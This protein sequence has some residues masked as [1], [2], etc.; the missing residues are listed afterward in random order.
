MVHHTRLLQVKRAIP[1]L[2]RCH[3]HRRGVGQTLLV[4][5]GVSHD[6]GVRAAGGALRHHPPHGRVVVASV[7]RKD[8]DI[9]VTHVSS[10]ACG[11]ARTHLDDI[12]VE[13]AAGADGRHRV[14]VAST[15]VDGEQEL[16]VPSGAHR[17]T[18]DAPTVSD[19][20]VQ[21]AVGQHVALVL[22]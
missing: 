11:V 21:L 4:R 18:D 6:G 9:A 17:H 16:V 5:D 3:R 20:D 15:L 7:K 10:D 22:R 14:H 8:D 19:A 12:N 13:L 2:H 1:R